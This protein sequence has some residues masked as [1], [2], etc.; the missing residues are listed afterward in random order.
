MSNEK[1]IITDFDFHLIADFFRGLDRQGPGS[2]EATRLALQ[3]AGELPSGARIA[4]IGCGTGGQT[5]L[6][7]RYTDAH[8]T[9]VDIMP[10]FAE[11]LGR[12]AEALGLDGRISAVVA[13]MDDLPFAEGEFDMIWAEGSIAHIGYER[14]LRQW[15]KYLK[16]EGVIAVSEASWLTDRRPEEIARFWTGGYPQIDRICVK[17]AQMQE[18]GYLPVAHFVLPETCWHNYLDPIKE[19]VGPFLER[20]TYCEQARAL[21]A[22]LEY[23]TELYGKYKAY[24]GYGFYIGRVT[25]EIPDETASGSG[26]VGA[27]KPAGMGFRIR[28]ER[29]DDFG[30][31][32]DL[33]RVAFETAEVKNGD[34]QDFAVRLRSGGI[35][36]PELALVAEQDGRL[37]GHIMF[38][39]LAVTRPDGTQFG[40]LLV[41]PLSVALE[42][43]NCG[44]GSALMREGFRRAAEM[45]Y[46]AAFLCGDPG[47]YSRLGYR[48]VS[49]FGIRPL[50]DIPPQY[51]QACELMPGGLDGVTGTVRL[52]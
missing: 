38:T 6:L 13:S 14:G 25:P 37:I 19:H 3:L 51:V 26:G 41:A 49:E 44:V 29:P 27:E 7:A 52:V 48:P 50:D 5:L 4:D 15:R 2:E 22:E 31:V 36:I 21:A 46:K 8:I 47:Y 43:R 24:Y 18:A 45:G 33:I 16:P 40:A 39:K 34:E 30:A 10:E 17:V 9:A 11:D 32:Y 12:R 42:F 35:Y 20:H 23:E 28:A 1:N